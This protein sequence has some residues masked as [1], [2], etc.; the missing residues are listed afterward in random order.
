MNFISVLKVVTDSFSVQTVIL[1]LWIM[2]LFKIHGPFLQLDYSERAMGWYTLPC[3]NC[4]SF[5]QMSK[6]PVKTTLFPH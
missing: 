5:F 3:Q 1:P 4:I 2:I 6:G